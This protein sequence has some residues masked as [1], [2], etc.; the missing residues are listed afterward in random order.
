[1]SSL[2]IITVRDTTSAWRDVNRVRVWILKKCRVSIGP[3]AGAKWRFSVSDRVYAIAGIKQK[4][5]LQAQCVVV[6]FIFLSA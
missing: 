2:K 3:D 1:M 4:D 6:S 5:T